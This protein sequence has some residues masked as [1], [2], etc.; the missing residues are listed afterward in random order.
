MGLSYAEEQLKIRE[1]S[2]L[3]RIAK[4]LEKPQAIP[5]LVEPKDLLLFI[6]KVLDACEHIYADNADSRHFISRMLEKE[7]TRS[8]NITQKVKP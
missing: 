3:D 4:A 1:I 7:L 8:F 5:N 6:K 2:I